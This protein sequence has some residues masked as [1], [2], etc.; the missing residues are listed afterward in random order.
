MLCRRSSIY[1]QSIKSIESGLT[2]IDIPAYR[3]EIHA[4]IISDLTLWPCTDWQE[5]RLRYGYGG[6]S[7]LWDPDAT[8]HE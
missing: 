6:S 2:F 1:I 5:W 4:E 8:D 7:E 3:R